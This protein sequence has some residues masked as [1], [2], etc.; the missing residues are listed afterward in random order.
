MKT[1][2]ITTKDWTGQKFG[3]L[4]FIS[5]T[6]NRSGSKILWTCQCD[7]GNTTIVLPNNV[8]YGTTKSCGCLSTA[9]DWT[10]QKF[11]RLTFISPTDKKNG[12]SILWLL[13]CECGKTTI[14]KPSSVAFGGTK[15]CGCLHRERTAAMGR[16]AAKARKGTGMS[17]A[18][19]RTKASVYQRQRRLDNPVFRLRHS[20]SVAIGKALASRGSSKGGSCFKALGYTPKELQDHL[21]NQFEWWMT[22]D[23]QG[24]YYP[25]LWDNN[26]PTTWRWQVDHI[27]P[28]SDLPY[29]SM[30]EHNFK[31]CWALNNLRP[32]S[33]KQNC[34]DGTSRVRH[35]SL[36]I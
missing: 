21:A 11:N 14:A 4:R 22:V 19:R 12:T 6:G 17:Y 24:V 7:C 25:K 29:T 8:S 20:I 5:P 32:L 28:Q 10:G 3:H 18:E 31:V 27:T 13:Q 9:K 26:D 34:L 36:T 1:K 16:A 15:S 23:N 35:S 30:E 33:A 2:H